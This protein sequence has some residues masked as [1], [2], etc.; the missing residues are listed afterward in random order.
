MTTRPI[1]T[2]TSTK[3]WDRRHQHLIGGKN[4]SEKAILLVRWLNASPT[5]SRC[6][7]TLHKTSNSFPKFCLYSKEI[8]PPACIGAGCFQSIWSVQ[9]PLPLKKNYKKKLVHKY[10]ETSSAEVGAPLLLFLVP[11]FFLH[12]WHFGLTVCYRYGRSCRQTLGIWSRHYSLL[13]HSYRNS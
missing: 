12:C 9:I 3:F 13:A 10:R 5:K 7:Q 2:D 8:L 6:L 4:D 1:F 11:A